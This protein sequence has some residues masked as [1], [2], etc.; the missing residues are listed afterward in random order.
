[1]EGC[2]VRWKS[3]EFGGMVWNLV[4]GCGI[5]WQGVEFDG[6]MWNLVAGCG[7]LSRVY[8]LIAG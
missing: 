1:M 3:V 2:G 8:N 6:R 7:I 5:W 4:A